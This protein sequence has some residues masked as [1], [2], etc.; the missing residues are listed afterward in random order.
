MPSQDPAYQAE[1]VDRLRL[2][3]PTISDTSFAL[4][5]ALQMSTISAPGHARLYARLTLLV[6]DSVIEHL[7]T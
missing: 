4:G 3:F 7:C 2:R 6:A 1:V 5:D